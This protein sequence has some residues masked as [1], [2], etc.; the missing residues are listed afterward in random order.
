MCRPTVF[1]QHDP[2]LQSYT[3]QTF[4]LYFLNL[5]LTFSPSLSSCLHSPP[6]SRLFHPPIHPFVHI[7]PEGQGQYYGYGGANGG[8][9]GGGGGGGGGNDLLDLMDDEPAPVSVSAARSGSSGTSLQCVACYRIIFYDTDRSIEVS[10]VIELLHSQDRP[11]CIIR[12]HIIIYHGQR[13]HV[14]I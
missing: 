9:G 13:T 2:V 14:Q 7:S 11:L 6:S 5:L 8:S 3:F 10:V 4:S 1:R 12:P